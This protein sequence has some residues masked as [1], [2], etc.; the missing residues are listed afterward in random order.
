[1]YREYKDKLNFYFIYVREAH[2]TD[3]RQTASNV[4]A[5]ILVKSPTTTDERA[6]IASNCISTLGLT[7]PCLIDNVDNAIQKSYQGWP[8]RACIVNTNGVIEF[9]SAPGPKGM[10]PTEIRKA[11][12]AHL[13]K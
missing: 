1:M 10:N 2:P 13:G 4:R 5:K 11:I 7:M 8:A 12:E 6:L 3:G 9:I